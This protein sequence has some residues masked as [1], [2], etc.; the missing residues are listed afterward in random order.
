MY[1]G[2]VLKSTKFTNDFKFSFDVT[3]SINKQKPDEDL[4]RLG[5]WFDKWKN[6]KD[7]QVQTYAHL[8]QT[9]KFLQGNAVESTA[10]EKKF[11]GIITNNFKFLK[12][13]IEIEKSAKDLKVH[14]A[15]IYSSKQ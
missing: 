14:K 4:C 11:S 7:D 6:T 15:V 5:N 3:S 1:D 2:I 12:K 10:T 13:S 8:T 9:K